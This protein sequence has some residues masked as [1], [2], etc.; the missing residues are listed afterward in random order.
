MPDHSDS[1]T[2][3]PLTRED[4]EASADLLNAIETVDRIGENYTAEDTL[5]ELVDPYA[6]LARASLAAFDGDV[7]VGFM[8]VR[9]KPVAQDV[10][11]VFLDGG[12]HPDHRRRGVGAALVDAGV[13]AAKVVHAL[14]HPA[15][16]LVVDVH[17]AEHIAGLAD[18][19]RSRGFAPVRY[20]QRLE[21]PLGDALGDAAIPEGLR[22][23][24]WSARN[25]EDFRSVRNESYQDYW[26]AVPM[27]V[28][29]WQNKITNQTFRPEVSFLLR[30]AADGAPVGVL[31]TLCWDA[32]SAATGVRDAHF[33]LVGTV[34]AYRKRGVAGALVGHALR[35]AAEQG[36]DR[37]SVSVDSA[38]PSGASGIFARAGFTPTMRYVRW[39]LE[40]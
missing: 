27:P 22:V 38:S 35:A 16:K 33:M 40:V 3:R 18:L 17:K 25:D 7:M 6:D 5:Q 14:H 13:A 15:L 8:K 2:W 39:A 20:F 19:V 30:D 23:E 37:A 28:D 4:A 26:G 11:R 32:D 12:V 31:V 24:P 1:L 9:H 29:S 21:H 34:R 36:Y 10:H